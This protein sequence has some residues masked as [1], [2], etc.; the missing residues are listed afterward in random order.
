MVERV[1]SQVSL[2]PRGQISGISNT[3]DVLLKI[4]HCNSSKSVPNRPLRGRRGRF[5]TL[6]QQLECG[7]FE[8]TAVCSRHGVTWDSQTRDTGSQSRH[9]RTV[10]GL[11]V[12]LGLHRRSAGGGLE[13]AVGILWSTAGV[14]PRGRG[15]GADETSRGRSSTQSSFF[16]CVVQF[17]SPL[18]VQCQSTTQLSGPHCQESGR[19]SGCL[20]SGMS[21]CSIQDGVPFDAD[22]RAR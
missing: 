21:C 16:G 19:C 1:D 14:R 18:L 13:G 17:T 22:G 3:T 9:G 11:I 8:R 6:L 7:I 12:I 5:G 10:Y 2:C 4:P 15:V 20:V